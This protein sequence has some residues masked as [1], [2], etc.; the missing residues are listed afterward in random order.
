MRRDPTAAFDRLVDDVD[1]AAVLQLDIEP[2]GVALL[3]RRAQFAIVTGRVKRKRSRRD[4]RVEQV[5]NG[6]A[7]PDGPRIDFVHGPV[8]F[9]PDHQPILRIE[10]AQTLNHVVE[11]AVEPHILLAELLPDAPSRK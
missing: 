1:D 6:A 9:V 5:A 2:K 10:H 11:R 8:S 4:A 7:A 3:E